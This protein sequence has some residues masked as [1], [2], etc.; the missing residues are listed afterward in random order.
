MRPILLILALVLLPTIE[1][2]KKRPKFPHKGFG[3]EYCLIPKAGSVVTRAILCDVLKEYKN[4]T[5]TPKLGA[6]TCDANHDYPNGWPKWVRSRKNIIFAV[7]RDPLERFVSTY[8]F[9]C[10]FAKM[11]ATKVK[12]IHQF[13]SWVHR[14]QTLD[15]AGRRPRSRNLDEIVWHSWPQTK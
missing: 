5:Y 12:N 13:A 2:A 10:K 7:V 11:C 14:L 3:V 1:T 8:E 6:I 4:V 9:L 15:F